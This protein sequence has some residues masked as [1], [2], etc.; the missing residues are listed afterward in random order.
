MINISHLMYD[1]ALLLLTTSVASLNKIWRAHHLFSNHYV[2]ITPL[3]H[4]SITPLFHC[5]ITPLFHYFITPLLY[6]SNEQQECKYKKLFLSCLHSLI[7][8][9]DYIY[10]LCVYIEWAYRSLLVLN[11][12]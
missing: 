5:S 9:C 12:Q 4:C 3:L 1:I 8:S 11:D 7:F 2:H 10:Q 6:L